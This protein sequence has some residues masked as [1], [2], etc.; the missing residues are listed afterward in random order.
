MH[1]DLNLQEKQDK[2]KYVTLLLSQG[3]MSLNY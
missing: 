1:H 3:Q 2:Y